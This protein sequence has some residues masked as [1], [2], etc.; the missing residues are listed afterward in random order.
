MR[1]GNPVTVQR[2]INLRQSKTSSFMS[3]RSHPTFS[4]A[5]STTA[6]QT[7]A[8]TTTLQPA[9]KRLDF[10][11]HVNHRLQRAFIYMYLAYFT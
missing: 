1:T 7:A 11:R 3:L 8:T 4:I 9:E 5:M 10:H 2:K 6:I